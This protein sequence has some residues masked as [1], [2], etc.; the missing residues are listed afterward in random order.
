MVSSFGDS[1]EKPVILHSIGRA[2]AETERG[3]D[4]SFG[5]RLERSAKSNQ[6]V[7]SANEREIA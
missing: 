1:D 5:S 6:R 4:P 3:S 2:A 7:E